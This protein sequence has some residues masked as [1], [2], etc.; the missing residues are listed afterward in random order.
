[1]AQKIDFLILAVLFISGG[2]VLA[3]LAS[4]AV[5][6]YHISMLYVNVVRKHYNGSWKIYL[7]SWFIRIKRKQNKH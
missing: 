7:K 1:M 5:I 6:I 2:N 3:A 4:V